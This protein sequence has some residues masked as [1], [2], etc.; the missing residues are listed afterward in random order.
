LNSLFS[1]SSA[2]IISIAQYTAFSAWFGTVSGAPN[3][4]MIASLIYLSTTPPY[5]FDNR[6]HPGKVFIECLGKLAQFISHTGGC[7]GTT[8][9]DGDICCPHALGGGPCVCSLQ[10]DYD[11]E[12]HDQKRTLLALVQSGNTQA[13]TTNH[14]QQHSY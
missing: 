13:F 12:G 11:R 6:G 4:A 5:L 3:R 8:A 9:A 1:L 7:P 2:S 10:K 14:W